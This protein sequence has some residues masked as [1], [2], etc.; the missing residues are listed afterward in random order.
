M[1][2]TIGIIVGVL[3]FVV[4]AISGYSQLKSGLKE[5][6]S[7]TRPIFWTIF[8]FIKIYLL[9]VTIGAGGFFFLLPLDEKSAVGKRS[10]AL[11]LAEK[12]G[13]VIKGDEPITYI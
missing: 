6:A 3:G 8:I 10:I 13:L 5:L 4:A 11:W 2:E 9:W 1:L 12:S 7:D